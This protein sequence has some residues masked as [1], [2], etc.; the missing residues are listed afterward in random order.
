MDVWHLDVYSE[1]KSM[2]TGEEQ[3]WAVDTNLDQ[4]FPLITLPSSDYIVGIALNGVFYF[5]GS[6]NLGYDVFAPKA[7]G[8]HK[9]P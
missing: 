4:F 2:W 6:S 9:N 5:A 8:T 7:Y 3:E 1:Y